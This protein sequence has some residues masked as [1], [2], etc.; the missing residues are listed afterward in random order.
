MAITGYR[1]ALSQLLCTLTVCLY[2]PYF[3]THWCSDTSGFSWWKQVETNLS[4]KIGSRS[5]F[6]AVF[7]FIGGLE[8][9]NC[10][11][12]QVPDWSLICQRPS[13]ARC[14][15]ESPAVSKG[16]YIISSCSSEQR[17]WR[18][19]TNN[20]HTS[21]QYV[22]YFLFLFSSMLSSNVFLYTQSRHVSHL[23]IRP[24]ACFIIVHLASS[25]TERV[26][27]LTSH[28]MDYQQIKLTCP[29]ERPE[30]LG[31]ICCTFH[32]S[33]YEQPCQTRERC[34][35]ALGL[36][37]GPYEPMI[38]TY[39]MRPIQKMCCLDAPQVEMRAF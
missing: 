33:F 26:T 5:S 22:H 6:I 14:H 37:D 7:R 16:L 15:A 29:L 11:G 36:P 20:H 32:T 24:Q 2:F 31:A 9:T 13:P 3:L 19:W 35:L 12:L 39:S 10:V 34:L 17:E 28:A 8:S 1:I 21:K 27:I 25:G 23:S 38:P 30:L 4:V 18:S